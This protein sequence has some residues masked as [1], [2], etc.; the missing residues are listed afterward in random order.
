MKYNGL[1]LT[2]NLFSDNESIINYDNYKLVGIIKCKN[3]NYSFSQDINFNKLK[4]S[5]LISTNANFN[6]IDNEIYYF[7]R[8]LKK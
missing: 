1:I 6:Y 5:K 3:G 7:Y 8:N 2:T 4:K